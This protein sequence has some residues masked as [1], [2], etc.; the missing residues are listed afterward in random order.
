ML[1]HNLEIL[2]KYVFNKDPGAFI[3]SIVVQ[4]LKKRKEYKKETYSNHR[5]TNVDL[6]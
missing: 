3:L 5:C 1:E 6:K 4:D 2:N